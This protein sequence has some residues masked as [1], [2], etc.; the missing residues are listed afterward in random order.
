MGAGTPWCPLS[1]VQRTVSSSWAGPVSFDHTLHTVSVRKALLSI[2]CGLLR[3]KMG[4]HGNMTL[5]VR[6]LRTPGRVMGKQVSA[7]LPGWFL[8]P[9]FLS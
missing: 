4:N 9:L 6:D 7:V 1:L 5:S 8:S 3:G 2:R